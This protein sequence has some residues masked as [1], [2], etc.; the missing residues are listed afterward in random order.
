L[1][2]GYPVFVPFCASN[3]SPLLTWD[4]AALKVTI[5]VPTNVSSFWFLSNFFTSEF[6]DYACNNYND[7][8]VVL[9]TPRAPSLLSDNIAFDSQGNPISADTRLL[10][11]CDPQTAGGQAYACP[12]GSTT[13]SETGFDAVPSP[14]GGLSKNHGATGW[15][16]TT[17]PVDSQKGKDITLV[18][19]IWDAANELYDSTALVDAF[20]WSSANVSS[21][22]TT[23]AQ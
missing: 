13:L 17:A 16:K 18:F 8:F 21:A 23:S 5:R 1:P 12:L 10:N 14:D 6:P 9:M 19:A 15:L 3:Q 11:V 20:T 7:Y 4:C 22:T 2:A